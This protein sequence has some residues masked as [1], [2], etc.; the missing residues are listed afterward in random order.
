MTEREDLV[1]TDHGNPS[2]GSELGTEVDAIQLE[3]FNSHFASIAEQMGATLQKTALSVNV[4]ERLDF[5][6]ALFD[7]NGDLVVNAPHIPVHLGAMSETVK[8]LVEDVPGIRTGDVYHLEL[9][10][11]LDRRIRKVHIEVGVVTTTTFSLV[12]G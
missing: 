2:T 5:S 8:C 10:Q 4:K 12:A 1:L 3:L 11:V 6:C 7:P 9:V